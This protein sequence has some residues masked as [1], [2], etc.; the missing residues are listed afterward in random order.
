MSEVALVTLFGMFSL[1]II[2][3]AV[4]AQPVTAKAAIKIVGAVFARLF[5]MRNFKP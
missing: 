4:F 5:G 3:L 1:N 2:V